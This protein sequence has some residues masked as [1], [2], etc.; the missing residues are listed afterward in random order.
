M[1]LS[2]NPR[3]LTSPD[4]IEGARLVIRQV[5]IHGL[6]RALTSVHLS[7]PMIV[8]VSIHGLLRALTKEKVKNPH[9]GCFN[10]RALTSPDSAMEMEKTL[11]NVSIHGLLRALTVLVV[12][13]RTQKRVSIHGLLRALTPQ[14]P[15]IPLS[16]G[17]NPRALTSPD[18][19]I[20]LH[21]LIAGFQSTGSYEP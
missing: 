21:S 14:S 11:R 16:A 4:E 12:L 10:P 19:L 5:S 3:A 17:F 1:R 6:L 2:F 15:W 7:F 8:T 18:S 20:L 13:A 9:M